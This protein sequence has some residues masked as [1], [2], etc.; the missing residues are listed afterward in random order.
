MSNSGDFPK[1]FRLRQRF[2][3]ACIKDAPAEVH[4]QL[5]ALNLGE[6]VR[7]GQSVAITAGSR[8]IANIAEIT[9]AIVDHFKNLGAKPFIVPA[10]G[11]HGG[12][13]AEGQ[14]QV[15]ESYGI[16]EELVG[17]P[18]R[19]SLETVEVCRSDH[20][21]PVHFDRLA[22]QADHV[23]VCNRVKPHSGFHGPIESGL[24]KM[25]LIG[26]GNCEG[27]KIYHRAILDHSF[28]QIVRSVAEKVITPV[29]SWPAWRLWKT[30]MTKPH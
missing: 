1:I 28:E 2:D 9:R 30:P 7:P 25:L 19:S 22:F 11:S 6:K 29:P 17:C 4:R 13:T 23:L 18:I 5:A 12:G 14:R 3:S 10:M 21:F 27:A 15:I 16:T 24:M 8:G 26:L 20:G